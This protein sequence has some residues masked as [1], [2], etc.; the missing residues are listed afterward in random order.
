MVRRSAGR[1]QQGETTTSDEACALVGPQEIDCAAARRLRYIVCSVILVL[2]TLGV[3][4]RALDCEFIYLDDRAY[5]S[6]NP[7]V[8]GGLTAKGFA[9]AFTTT[10]VSN[11][12]PLTWLS[13]M[14]DC[15]L[16]G[17]RPAGHHL[18]NILLHSANVW[19][20][21]SLLMSMTG[22][23]WCCAVAAAAFGLHPA[24]VESVA[25]V[26]ER[27]D[28][29]STFFGF[30]ALLAYVRYTRRPG[31]LRYVVVTVL[32][33]LG[34]AAKPMLVTWPCVMLLLD[35]WPL[36]RTDRAGRRISASRLIVEKL[37][38]FALV[39]A[40]SAVTVYAQQH[41]GAVVSATIVSLGARV[42]NA[43]T[44]YVAYLKMAFWPVG[45]AV[46]YP[47]R[48]SSA[49]FWLVIEALVVLCAISVW[50]VRVWRPKRYA[51]VGWLWYLGTLVPVIGL[52]QVGTQALADRYTYVP[53]IGVSL[54]VVW[55]VGDLIERKYIPRRLAAVVAVA[56]LAAMAV[57][58]RSQLHHWRNS[59][60]LFEHALA[61][62]SDNA[63]VHVFLAQT[64]YAQGRRKDALAHYAEAARIYP[65][66]MDTQYNYG[67]ALLEGGQF[68]GAIERFSRVLRRNPQN[69]AAR[70]YLEKAHKRRGRSRNAK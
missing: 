3:Y 25:W 64:L 60:A 48:F 68:D 16:F 46:Y 37:P 26:A 7:N 4:A 41:G 21:F 8:L 2:V 47:H 22:K 10:H 17:G 67:L 28:L 24:H 30:L 5:V 36:G 11:W 31:V 34:L 69:A 50:T 29:L 45:L 19:L 62:T 18:T 15:E 43:L 59:T 39:A 70:F 35:Y 13:H 42:T 53:L 6:E 52:V 27:K 1:R 33:A 65:G 66:D 23:L 14:L 61:V 20:L 54:I 57:G 51:I 55:S 12:H 56:C 40:S 58:T 9:W 32:L 38:L 44:S 49:P 63:P